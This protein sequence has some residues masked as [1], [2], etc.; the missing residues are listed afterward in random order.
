MRDKLR[1]LMLW[2]CLGAISLSLDK[3]WHSFSSFLPASI[4]SLGKEY[5]QALPLTIGA[6][7]CAW[8]VAVFGGFALGHLVGA[9]E[10]NKLDHPGFARIGLNLNMVF[11]ALY[12]I[13]FVL[14]ISLTSSLAYRAL[15]NFDFSGPIVVGILVAV[16]GL[17]LGGFQ[18]YKSVYESV[19]KAKNE[20]K[21]L[22][23]A[24]YFRPPRLA[25]IAPFKTV[26]RLHDCEITSFWSAL[27]FAAHLS[28]VAIMILEAIVPHFYE[29]ILGNAGQADAWKS[30]LGYLVS[31]AQYNLQYERV[32][33]CIWLILLIDLIWTTAI[34]FF[35]YRTWRRFY[36]A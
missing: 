23:D 1:Q 30:G 15:Y 24:L 34:D 11:Q 31:L 33:G 2:G 26:S 7:F 13:P 21:V 3:I 16:A 9:M 29:L 22:V 8:L 18:V 25:V 20:N 4:L 17:T 28:I 6:S 19:A 5:W 36:G 35:S 14:T 12:V 27:E 32:A 10:L